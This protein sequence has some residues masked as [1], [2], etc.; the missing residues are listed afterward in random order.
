M[1][2]CEVKSRKGRKK[3]ME[4]SATKQISNC[5]K[6]TS[7]AMR[8]GTQIQCPPLSAVTVPLI[9]WHIGAFWFIVEIQNSKG[10]VVVWLFAMES[11]RKGGGRRLA[12]YLPVR[13]LASSI[14]IY[15]NLFLAPQ[16]SS[17]VLVLLHSWL[18]RAG[19]LRMWSSHLPSQPASQ[20][21]SRTSIMVLRLTCSPGH[22][23]K[24]FPQRFNTVASPH[25]P[26]LP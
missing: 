15:I 17:R 20:L 24:Q 14:S 21:L 1:V 10:K 9:T 22:P 8:S 26:Q 3:R 16:R 7:K 5:R 6:Y 2:G 11:S 19:R 4:R 25:L 12:N 23:A 18:S 13:Y